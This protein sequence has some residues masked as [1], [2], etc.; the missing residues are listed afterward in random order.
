MG[1]QRLGTLPRS[2]AWNQ[3]I[4]LIAAG[5]EVADVASA[6]SGAAEQSMIDASQDEVVRHTMWILARLPLAAREDDFEAALTR[7]GIRT[8]GVITLVDLV[9]AATEA[10]DQALDGS[11]KRSNYGEIAQLSASEALYAVVG[12]EMNDLFGPHARDTKAALRQFCIPARFAVLARDFFARLTRRH[13]DYFLSRELGRHVGPGRR[14]P[15]IREHN[16]F[17]Q[18]LENHCRQATRVIKEYAGMWHSKQ[19]FQGGITR[20]KA[21]RFLVYASEK[22]RDELRHRRP[23]DVS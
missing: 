2:K 10:V 16:A 20:A 15:S 12:R 21:A 23:A 1:H 5:A 13:F 11:R 4:A 18:A 17:E 7:L 22:I 6:T 19:T 14:F 9:C 8:E 3:V